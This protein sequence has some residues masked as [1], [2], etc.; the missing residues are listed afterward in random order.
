VTEHGGVQPWWLGVDIGGTRTKLG[1]VGAEG[2]VRRSEVLAT[3]HEPF[4]VIWEHLLEYARGA[5]EGEGTAGLRGIGIAAPGI[6]EPGFGVRNLPGKV[7][8]IE[9]F[10]LRERLE[11][12]F[13]VPVRCVNDGAAATLAEWRFGVARGLQDVVGLTIGTGVGVGVVIGGRLLVSRHLGAGISFGHATIETGGRTCLCGNIGCAETL[14]SANA[15]VGRMRDAVARKVPSTIT[16]RYEQDPGAITFGALID[17]VEVDDRVGL[18]I[19]AAFQRDLGATIVTAIHAYDPELVVLAG[20]PMAA[21]EHFLPQVQTYVDRY[22]FRFPKDRIVPV[23]RAERSDHAGVLGAVALVMQV[24]D[25]GA[26]GVDPT[27][28]KDDPP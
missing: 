11:A 8:G 10:P 21:A 17:A 5:Q 22:A 20:G 12:R 3:T 6:V 9:D 18:E 28:P 1:V 27:D 19:M 24:T 13:G 26:A 2:D 16:A 15:V 7:Q 14:V 25:A 23:T 4:D